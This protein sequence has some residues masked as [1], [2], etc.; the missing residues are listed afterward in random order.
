MRRW[1][2]ILLVTVCVI[3]AVIAGV[4]FLPLTEQEKTEGRMYRVEANRI[5]EKI[6]REGLS[7]VDVSEYDT[8]TAVIPL[9]S[10][11]DKETDF[12]E[13][14]KED[15]LIREANGSY[16]RIDYLVDE[17]RSFHHT[18]LVMNFVLIGMSLFLLGVLLFVRQKILKPFSTLAE[19][20]F[21]L[22]KG[23]LS[24]PIKENKSRY[25]GR[26]VWGLDLLRENLEEQK[27]KELKLQKEK[28]TLVLS[29]SH[30][31]K[32]PLSAIKLYAKALSKGLYLEREKQNEI[33]VS[34]NAKADEIE[35]FVSQIVQASRGDF[36][37]FDV[38]AGEFY[39]SE[40]VMKLEQ[41]YKDKQE[42]MHISLEMGSYKDCLLKGDL[43]RGVEVLQNIIENAIKYGDGEVLQLEI[44]REEDCQLVTVRN[45][46]CQ[47]QEHELPHVF[48]SFWR[49]SNA[50]KNDGSGLGLYIC[51][52]LM[53]KMDGE[54]YAEL[55]NGLM[56]V[57][58]VFR[59]L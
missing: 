58:T 44:V 12:F 46:G 21:E 4:N 35:G 20:P 17:S 6:E 15:Y 49:G 8:I 42:V 38:A 14:E 1:D 25:F 22:S 10:M 16:Y 27:Q 37:R 3:V 31:I 30:D 9:S 57:T 29:I 56:S 28:K 13:G 11:P 39:L 36:L 54:V 41:Y 40:L 7:A 18:R 52:Q 45:S 32:T 26:F 48:E 33:A 50:K 23:N 2:K 55:D 59:M 53:R 19:V 51:R 43:S 24:V 34:I 5:I 47:L